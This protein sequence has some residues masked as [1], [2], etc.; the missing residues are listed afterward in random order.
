MVA[1]LRR[2]GLMAAFAGIAIFGL[3]A[4]PHAARADGDDRIGVVKYVAG[5]ASLV[6]GSREAPAAVGD[7]ILEGDLLRTG[8][9]GAIGFM[10]EDGARFSIGADSAI[11]MREFRFQPSKG[12]FSIIAEL[13]Y[14]VMVHSTGEVGRLA[15]EAVKIETAYGDV[16][17]RGTRFAV[18]QPRP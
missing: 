6:R 3:A 4:A 10:L 16:G 12:L 9:D 14:G 13:F 17:V 5:A 18:R 2:I 11:E 15:P 8:A 7:V 1:A